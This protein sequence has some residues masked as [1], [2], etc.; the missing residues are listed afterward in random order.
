MLEAFET[1]VGHW[2]SEDKWPFWAVVLI[3]TAIGRFTDKKLFTRERAYRAW[4]RPWQRWVWFWGRETLMV[5]PVAAGIALGFFLWLD[6]EGKGWG[7]VES[8]GY[9]GAAGVVS[10][11]AWAAIRSIA[12]A[13]GVSLTLPGESVR[14][15][16]GEEG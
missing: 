1:F 7:R 8:A 11:F 2:L 4:E 3:F 14:P 6:P 5:H 12:K 10:L 15:G 13:R 9:F 16:P